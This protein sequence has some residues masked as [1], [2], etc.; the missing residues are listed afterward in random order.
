MRSDG[1]PETSQM[2]DNSPEKPL[3]PAA[4]QALLVDDQSF[5]QHRPMGY[6]PERPE[7]LT[8]ARSAAE[9]ANVSWQRVVVREAT[10]EQLARVHSP[11]FVESLEK[12]RG[13]KGYL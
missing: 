8:A 10:D 1:A 13:R 11:A 9:H 12:L 2:P 4:P 3:R 7:R 6:H 5:E